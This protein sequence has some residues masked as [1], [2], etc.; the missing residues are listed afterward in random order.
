MAIIGT[1]AAWPVRDHEV[2]MRN[3]T[4]WGLCLCSLLAGCGDDDDARAPYQSG[5]TVSAPVATLDTRQLQQIC[6]SF[7]AYVDTN[8]G[9]DQIAY[10]A[11]LPAAIVLG[12]TKEGCAQQLDACMAAFP[13]PVGVQAH[14]H[15]PDVCFANLQQCQAS[16]SALEN[17]VNVNL[18]VAFDVLGWTCSRAGDADLQKAA[19]RA[20]NTAQ[21][22]GHV[23]AACNQ[24][25][26]LGP[27]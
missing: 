17:C 26:T 7:D 3:A 21:V 22:C 6:S 20:M 11:C 14:V 27:D 16:V 4:I 13:Q 23:D 19:A 12:G 25:A 10:I 15:D 5:I 8:I 24:F 2:D 9:F 1:R 18:D